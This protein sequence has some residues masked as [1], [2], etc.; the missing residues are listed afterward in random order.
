MSLLNIQDLNI[1]FALPEQ[2]VEAV[3]GISFEIQKGSVVGIVGESGSGKSVTALSI[4]Q[5]LAKT[6]SVEG[7]IWH[8]EASQ[9]RDLIQL[10]PKVI[11]KYRG[12]VIGMIFQEPMSS[13]NPLFRCGEQIVEALQ[14]HKKIDKVNAKKS[15][16]NWLK[17]VQLQDAERI[18]KSYPHQLSGGQQQRVMIAMAMC[19]E[20][21]L[22]IADEPTTALD[23]QVQ[24]AILELLKSLQKERK[25]SILFISH[26]LG[27]VADL[28]DQ[29]IV[30]RNGKIVEA[31]E[32][33][34]IFEHPQH[35]YTKGLLACRPPIDQKLHRLPVIQDF[36]EEKNDAPSVSYDNQIVTSISTNQ[37]I[38]QVKELSTWFPKEKNIFGRPKSYV[39]AV[40]EV[41][42]DIQKGETLALVGE[43]GS[44]KTTLGRS[45]LRLVEPRSGELNFEGQDLLKLSAK[46]LRKLRRQI[47][48][49]FQNPYAALNPRKPVGYAIAEPMNVHG[50]AN[51]EEQSVELLEKVGLQADHFTRYPH[52]FSGGQRQR[53]CIARALALKPKFI[54]CDE[55]VSALDVS[56]QAQ[57]L[58]LLKDL[59]AEFDLSYLFIT[60]DLSVVRFIGDRV[61]VMKS[62]K[63]VERGSADEIFEQP[64]EAYTRNLLE[65]VL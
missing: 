47:Q 8:T 38:W 49:I 39:K 56:V 3:K 11:Q 55:C 46:E 2:T 31:G 65:A 45:I 6:A 58:N 18:F 33:Q 48:I 53:I 20:P 61:L 43:S 5:L 42:F 19:C 51:A 36:E 9:K 13:L 29:V 50:I 1:R 57:I 34:Q 30:M 21:D 28:A 63:I 7:Q 60:H 14:I 26:D 12:N 32:V 59:Q 64:K 15:V 24:K 40:D 54:V 44:G 10:S 16:L 4:L 27:V 41:S 37:N 22:L 35:P 25:M 17:K 52:E 23:V 62:G